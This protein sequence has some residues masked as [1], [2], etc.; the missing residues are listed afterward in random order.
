M[1]SM[2]GEGEILETEASRRLHKSPGTVWVGRREGVAQLRH[3]GGRS[4]HDRQG[5]KK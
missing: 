4:G 1:G 2:H 3:W 5:K